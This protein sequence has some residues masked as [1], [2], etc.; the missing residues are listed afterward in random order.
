MH[1]KP[2]GCKTWGYH[3]AKAWYLSHTAAHYQFIH[4]IMKDMGGECITDMF[5]YQHHV[6]PVPVITA[7]NCI[8]EATRCLANAINGVQEE[9]PDELAA[10]QSFSA[11]LLS[12]ET[13]QEPEPSPQPPRPEVRYQHHVI[14]VLV[15]TAPNCILEATRC[16][17]NAI[18]GVQEGSL[19]KLAA[20]Q[21]L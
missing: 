4:V 18:N 13:P 15:I 20:I 7:P 6:I 21:S 19:D 2:G 5:Q 11:L 10:I 12:K 9:P 16:L 17:A 3:A 8:L 1:Q 14:P